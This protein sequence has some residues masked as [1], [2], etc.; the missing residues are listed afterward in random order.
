MKTIKLNNNQAELV[1]KAISAFIREEERELLMA[2]EIG[3]NTNPYRLSLNNL[4]E[5]KQNINNQIN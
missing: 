1:L 5:L 2:E 4:R 3:L